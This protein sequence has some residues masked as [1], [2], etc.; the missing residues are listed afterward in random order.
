MGELWGSRRDDPSWKHPATRRRQDV[1]NG[2]GAREPD[3]ECW[4]PIP[5]TVRVVWSVD[6]EQW[7]KTMALGWTGRAAPLVYVEML[8]RRCRTRA[9]WLRAEDVKRR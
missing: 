5:I 8:D 3:H 6:G 2:T 1:L 9:I 7:I 4:P